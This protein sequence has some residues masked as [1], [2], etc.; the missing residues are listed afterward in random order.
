MRIPGTLKYYGKQFSTYRISTYAASASFFAVTAIFPLM[1]LILSVLS[2][3][4][5]GTEVFLQGV[6]MV[7]PRA[8]E[9]M[10]AYIA[11]DLMETNIITLSFSLLATLW[12]SSKSMLGILDGLNGIADVPY[13]GNFLLKRIVCIFYTLALILVLLITLTLR[14]FGESIYTLIKKYLPGI[15]GIFATILDF[16]GL[17]LFIFV[18][19]IL[20]LIYTFFP[21]KKVRFRQQLPGALFTSVVWILF[22]NLYSLYVDHVLTTSSIYGSLAMFVFAMLWIYFCMW[23]IFIGAVLNQMLPDILRTHK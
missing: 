4:P 14:V 17:T 22:S 8:F 12:T 1:M 2:Y 9:R 3:T 20:A 5:L 11:D 19:I 21:H 16:Q 13:N 18:T 15:S 23:I 10:F 6:S 7:I